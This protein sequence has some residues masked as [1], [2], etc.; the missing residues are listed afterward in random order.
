MITTYY[1][2]L[3]RIRVNP[4]STASSPDQTSFK[5]TFYFDDP[6]TGKVQYSISNSRTATCKYK[7]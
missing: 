5:C 4:L 7:I 6:E 3:Y 2:T 1:N